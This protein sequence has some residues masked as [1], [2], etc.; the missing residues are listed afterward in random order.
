MPRKSRKNVGIIG[1]GIIGTR[2]ATGLRAAGFQVFVWNRS[3]KP[4]P[5]FLGS[6]EEVAESCEIIQIFVSDA[7]ALI[8]VIEAMSESLTSSHVII[9]NATVG[10]EAVIAASKLV[11]S[12][13]AQFLDAPF[14]GSKAAAEKRELVY[15]IGGSESVLTRVRPVLEAT[16]KTI[17]KIGDI[18]HA[19][20]MKVVTNMISAVTTQTLAEALAI[21]Q[22]SG[23]TAEALG[24]AIA[25]NGCRS[26]LIEMKLPKM[27]SG[28]FEPHFSMRNMFKDVQLGIHLANTLNIDIPA[29][30]VTAGILFGAINQGMGDLD[31]S[32]LYKTYAGAPVAKVVTPPLVK[33]A[34]LPTAE[35]KPAIAEALPL[36]K[37]P[38]P[39]LPAA[40]KEPEPP[41]EP[42]S[43]KAAPLTPLAAPLNPLTPA[44]PETA[45]PVKIGAGE[46]SDEEI[47]P[48]G[49]ATKIIEAVIAEFRDL[50]AE[51][52]IENA[53]AE[54]E[55]DSEP[56]VHAEILA[57]ANGAAE[58]LPPKTAARRVNFVKRWFVSRTRGS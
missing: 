58:P 16:S 11:T 18:G 48:N 12:R 54:T 9:C 13:G 5:N 35:P 3:A 37:A 29:T 47:A 14:T 46:F 41:F 50:P 45:A 24:L 22:K 2:V 31:F 52:K 32:A 6:P 7:K 8:E 42:A 39:L 4:A 1:L 26:G 56:A 53:E 34:I 28:D 51:E 44:S 57:P 30:T 15:Y 20:T 27:A 49:E 21:V 25:H 40:R 36:E 23:L 17:V 38:A 33:K 19:S 10:S 55:T 43:L